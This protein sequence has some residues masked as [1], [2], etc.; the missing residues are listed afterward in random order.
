MTLTNEEGL[1]YHLHLQKGGV[2]KYVLL[3]GDPRWCELIAEHFDK[4]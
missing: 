1:Q 3:S 4:P 2:G